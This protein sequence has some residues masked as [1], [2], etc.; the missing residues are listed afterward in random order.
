MNTENLRAAAERATP[1]KRKA[2]Q[3]G[4]FDWGVLIDDNPLI[5]CSSG[6]TMDEG[7]RNA[8]YLE[9]ADPT[10]ILRLLDRMKAL[11]TALESISITPCLYELLG[12]EPEP[13]CGLPWL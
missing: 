6:N 5:M 12:E 9:A 8:A 7:E 10:T 11:R 2:Y 13:P 4:E 1:G 3:E